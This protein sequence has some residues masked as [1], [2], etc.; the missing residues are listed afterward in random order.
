KHVHRG[1]RRSAPRTYNRAAA[2][3][4]SMG[5]RRRAY[6]TGMGCVSPYGVGG[7]AF[8]AG[9]RAGRT[10]TRTVTSFDADD[11]PCRVAAEVPDFDPAAW[12]RPRDRQR[13]ARVVPLAVAA[14]HEALVA[15]R[16]GPDDL[17]E[18]LRRDF[19]VLVGSGAA[20]IGYAE[21]QLEAYFARGAQ[22]V[23]AF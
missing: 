16:L 19:H 18:R 7:A 17:P 3:G 22:A 4:S 23:S 13:V 9:L 1:L 11:L 8:D 5:A 14:A 10:A 6:V 12:L 15:A 21:A 20:C 2:E